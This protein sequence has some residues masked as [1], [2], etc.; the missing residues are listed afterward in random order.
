MR[1]PIMERLEAGKSVDMLALAVAGYSRYI[2]P[3]HTLTSHTPPHRRTRLS[4]ELRSDSL[5]KEALRS[6][7]QAPIR[8]AERERGSAVVR[9][10]LSSSR[11]TDGV[12]WL[13]AKSHC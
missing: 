1:G 4:C 3:Q 9:I 6:R 7:A 2:S 10:S 12:A 13:D 11:H 5:E 8:L